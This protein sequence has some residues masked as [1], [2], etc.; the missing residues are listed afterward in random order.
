MAK[1]NRGKKKSGMILFLL[2]LIIAGV[3]AGYV[4]TAPE[5]EREKPKIE[6]V[7][8]LYWNRKDPIGIKLSDNVALGSYELILSDGKK[9]VIIGPKKRSI[10]QW[11]TNV[12]M[13]I[14]LPIHG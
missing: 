8:T 1:R 6:S 5:F 7:D 10:L 13:S 9:A 14:S 3:G 4:Y 11:I 2:L 12:P